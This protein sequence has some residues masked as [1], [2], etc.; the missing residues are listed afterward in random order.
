LR[1]S[2][3]KQDGCPSSF[4]FNAVLILL[5]NALSYVKGH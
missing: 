1:A 2:N 3:E 4:N 5:G